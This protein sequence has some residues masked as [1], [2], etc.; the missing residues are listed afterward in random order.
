MLAASAL[1]RRS[2]MNPLKPFRL[3]DWMDQSSVYWS[4]ILITVLMTI[5]SIALPDQYP[6][7][8]RSAI[9]LALSVAFYTSFRKALKPA[10]PLNLKQKAFKHRLLNTPGGIFAYRDL[11]GNLTVLSFLVGIAYGVSGLLRVI[12]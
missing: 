11:M 1:K 12:L 2:I 4:V 9:F 5:L 10:H 6:S 3:F 8:D 7:V